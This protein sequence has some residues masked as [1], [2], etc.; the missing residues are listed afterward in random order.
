VLFE[1]TEVIDIHRGLLG[2]EGDNIEDSLRKFTAGCTLLTD[3]RR[4]GKNL[5]RNVGFELDIAAS[6]RECELP[7]TLKPPADL[8]VDIGTTRIA[9]ECKRPFSDASIGAN[10]DNGFRQL[11]HR[12]REH[13]TPSDVR[14]ILAL[15]GSKME[16]DGSRFLKGDDLADLNCSIEHV[17]N[18]FVAKTEPF[19]DHARDDRTIGIVVCLRAL[20]PTRDANIFTVVRHF[21][22]IGLAKTQVDQQLFRSLAEQFNRMIERRLQ[23]DHGGA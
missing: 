7:I 8:W 17:S 4:A 20:S 1:S 21:T 5:A 11:R 2:L 16:N 3:K 19:W 14:G 9:L 23:G 12:Y 22:W 18:G 15:S 13:S 6:F 10:L